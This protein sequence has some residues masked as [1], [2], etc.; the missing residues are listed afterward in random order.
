MCM[1]VPHNKHYRLCFL[2]LFLIFFSTALYAAPSNILLSDAAKRIGAELSWDPLQMQAAFLKDGHSA[3]VQANSVVV[4]FDNQEAAL[5]DPMRQSGGLFFI[6]SNTLLKINEFFL[7]PENAPQYRVGVILID[8]GHGG[9]DAGAIGSYVDNGKTIPVREKDVVLT[10]AKDLYRRL[11]EAYP[12]KKIM[13]TRTTDTYPSLD[14]RVDMA[15]KI[16]LDKHE[17]IVYISIHANASF[18]RKA[19]G[20]EVWYLTPEYRRTVIDKKNVSKEIQPI[21]N[22]MMEEEFTLES[23]LIAKKILAGMDTQLAKQSRNR[24][25]KEEA[26]FVVRNAKMPAVLIELGFVSNPDEARLLN[27][28]EYLKKC[29]LGIYN[30]LVDFITQFENSAGFTI[31]E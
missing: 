14:D 18:N 12:D 27:T 23:M 11:T 17:A 25:L 1:T 2:V 5:V 24:G 13:L 6:S 20:F 8:P 31:P 10:V 9:K 16:P 4:V 7:R 26:W 29:S 22:Q 30:G 19:R 21:L 15:N 28:P 3:T